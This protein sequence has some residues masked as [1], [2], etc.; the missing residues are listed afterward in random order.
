MIENIYP[1]SK[2]VI[3]ILF[4]ALIIYFPIFLHLDT[5]P[6]GIWDEARLVHSTMEMIH[7]HKC[8]IPY[9][10]GQIDT[11]YTKPPLMIW[12]QGMCVKMIGAKELAFRLPS[13]IAAVCTCM[14]LMG[15]CQRYL[16]CYRLGIITSAVLVTTPGYIALHVTRTCDYD[17]LLILWMVVY[18]LAFF[19]YT[20][21]ENPKWLYVF[22]IVL[23]LG[24]LTKGIAAL[25]PLPGI[26]VY[27][28]LSHKVASFLKDKHS[29]FGL[30]GFLLLVGG[31]YI[32]RE[33]LTPG[34]LALVWQNEGGGRFFQVIEEHR[35]G[36]DW[37]IDLI[38][39]HH[40]HYWQLGIPL[41]L[42][43]GFADKNPHLRKLTLF[44]FCFCFCYFLL[45]SLAKTKLSWYD[46][47]LYP[48]FAL[49]TAI[50]IQHFFQVIR[51]STNLNQGLRYNYLAYLLLILLFVSPYCSIISQVY[52]PVYNQRAKEE[53]GYEIVYWLRNHEKADLS[54]HVLLY[55]GYA[56]QIS[57]YAYYI[58]PIRTKSTAQISIG[59]IV[60]MQQ[61]P[62]KQYLEEKFVLEKIEKGEFIEVVKIIDTK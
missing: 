54:K 29:Y 35:G 58:I 14:A 52:F 5:L 27:S 22:F 48:F 40:Y 17:S 21:T 13:A 56:P 28:F 11:W 26:V 61:A 50:A 44:T 2:T 23:S 20:Q 12:F 55:D 33:S 45:I 39:K 43:I 37:Y 41:G 46:S 6:I 9:F 31:Y 53:Y 49:W 18:A 1:R 4:F 10:E 3:K 7:N 34:Y 42:Y 15:Y 32:V 30:G 57:C 19:R 24:A 47:P 25:L 60:I 38:N 62:L 51:E 8:L 59:D 36:F 16:N